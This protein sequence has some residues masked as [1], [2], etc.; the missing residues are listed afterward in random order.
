MV[1]HNPDI[2]A[3]LPRVVEMRDGAVVKDYEPAAEAV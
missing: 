2:A 3:R 1:T